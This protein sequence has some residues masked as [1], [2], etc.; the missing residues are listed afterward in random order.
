[1]T[2]DGTEKQ[3]SLPGCAPSASDRTY[4]VF[5]PFGALF[6]KPE[7]RGYT[8]KLLEAGLYTREEAER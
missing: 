5:R 6:W 3:M 8:A 7:R 4:L 1:M 2:S